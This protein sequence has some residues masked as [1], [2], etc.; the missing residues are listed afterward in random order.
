MLTTPVVPGATDYIWIL[1]QGWQGSSNTNTIEVIPN[2]QSDT[3]WLKIVKCDTSTA[4]GKSIY[5]YENPEAII[6]ANGAQLSTQQPHQTY[7]WY[8]NQQ[9]INGATSSSYTATQLGYYQVV[10][11]NEGS[12][13]DTSELFTYNGV[14]IGETERLKA[15]I[16]IYPNPTEGKLFINSPVKI[17]I[18]LCS[19]D[20]RALLEAKSVRMIDMAGWSNG[21]YLLKIFDQNN[22]FIKAEKITLNK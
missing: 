5:V 3:V 9:P 17:N 4:I 2:G 20:G 16:Q 19:I 6:V 8:Y 15:A 22:K 13:T 14:G 1:P 21:I 18:Q 10:V 11:T 7:Q 12:C